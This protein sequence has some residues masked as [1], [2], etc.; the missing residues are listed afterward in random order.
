MLKKGISHIEVILAFVIFISAVVFTL[1]FFQPEKGMESNVV[2]QLDDILSEVQ[3][4]TSTDVTELGIKLNGDYQSLSVT[5]PNYPK[6]ES[7]A[8]AFDN[9]GNILPSYNIQNGNSYIACAASSNASSLPSFFYERISPDITLN[10]ANSGIC[11]SSNDTYYQIASVSDRKI[12][13]EL[14][15][16]E[17]NKTYYQNYILLKNTFGI[18]RNQDFSFEIILPDGNIIGAYST[19]P[20]NVEI[21]AINKEIEV[22]RQDGKIQ[23]AEIRMRI[24]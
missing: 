14:K 2:L 10:N 23:F 17:I 12:V 16:L 13:S 18:G 22:L 7:N 20:S 9:M 21:F 1:F 15:L 6:M 5:L 11:S 3:K 8:S 4:N 19:I 24:W